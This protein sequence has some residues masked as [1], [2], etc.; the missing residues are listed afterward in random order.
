MTHGEYAS[1]SRADWMIATADGFVD[2]VD[3]ANNRRE[4]A[5]VQKHLGPVE[6][7][8]EV[9]GESNH[10]GCRSWKVHTHFPFG[11]QGFRLFEAQEE[12]LNDSYRN[13]VVLRSCPPLLP[14]S[15]E[16]GVAKIK[17]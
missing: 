6:L 2:C 3:S 15:A 11:S 5:I 1:E 16:R 13:M 12:S 14:A 4:R 17:A 10:G 7:R 8:C 9:L